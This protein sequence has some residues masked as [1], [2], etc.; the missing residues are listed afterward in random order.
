MSLKNI[1]DKFIKALFRRSN[2][3]EIPNSSKIQKPTSTSKKMKSS[4]VLESLK[5]E[6]AHQEMFKKMTSGD[7][8]GRLIPA[9][10][11]NALTAKQR[12]RFG[13]IV[14]A[15]DQLKDQYEVNT[16]LRM[17]H[18]WAQMA[19]ESGG[20]R[21]LEEI[22]GRQYFINRYGHR[23]DLGNVSP[24]DGYRY[25]GRGIIQLTGKYNYKLYSKKLGID[26]VGDP[27]KASEPAV[28]VKVA[29]EYWKDRKLNKWA[30]KDN[31]RAVTRRINGGYN[32]LADRKHYLTKTK[33]AFDI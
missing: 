11:H 33:K 28:A 6:K 8:L 15:F 20:F 24:L 1:L 27:D 21:W 2:S 4:E 10:R 18:F 32:G 14:A 17:A 19:H 16:P 26:L 3:P 22:G 30:D 13:A 9:V 29:L 7:L 5:V 23:R 25:R 31:I 12:T